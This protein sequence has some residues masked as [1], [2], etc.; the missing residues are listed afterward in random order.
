MDNAANYDE[1]KAA[2]IDH[3]RRKGYLKWKAVEKSNLYNHQTIR[4]RLE[5]IRHFRETNDNQGLLFTLNE[6]IH[7]NL[8]GMGLPS[9]YR[10]AKFGTKDL[11]NE[12]IDEVSSALEHLAKPRIKGVDNGE[13]FEFLHRASHCFGQSAFLMSGSGTYLFFHIGV[14]KS[15]WKQNLIPDVI[16]GSSGGSIVAALIGTR[17]HDNLAVIFDPNF[18]DNQIEIA[19]IVEK[20]ATLPDERI[21]F[22]DLKRM[23]DILIPDLTFQEAYK[24][25]GKKIN[26]SIA[27]AEKHQNSRLLNEV[28]SPNVLI[29]EA[30]MASCS[31]PG[32]FPP[33]S[34]SARDRH[35]ERVPYLPSQK[36]VDGAISDDLPMKRLSRLYGVNHFIVSQ[37][38]PLTLPFISAEKNRQSVLATVTETGMKT[39]VD[40]GLAA[41]HILQKPFNKDSTISKMINGYMSLVSQS[42]SGD[43]N[44]LPD[45]R[46]LNIAKVLKPKTIDEIRDLIQEGEK[47]TWPAIEKI[48]LQTKISRTLNRL[49]T[50]V[51]TRLKKAA[52]S[53]KSTDDGSDHLKVV[54]GGK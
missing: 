52:N 25:S 51:E 8:G 2:A 1:W 12:Y 31:V 29:R 41:S 44:I 54:K 38:N 11:I 3:D 30:V 27:P 10:R 26:I 47:A 13:K 20:T 42:Y 33:G 39:A 4:R 5:R 49:K 21:R 14:M 43:I 50:Q 23:V 45:R 28:T 40:W 9:L 37:I 34:L 15:L 7:G 18:L 35:G 22:G 53:S 17:D 16:S 36:W 46:L 6:G 32:V 48:R 24:I 19:K